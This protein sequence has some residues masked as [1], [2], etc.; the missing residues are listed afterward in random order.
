MIA[1]HENDEL[2]ILDHSIV[3]KGFTILFMKGFFRLLSELAW[4]LVWLFALLIIGYFV[5]SWLSNKFSGNIIGTG[6]TWVEQHA[7]PGY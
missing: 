7:Q 5:L 6:A 1:I 3:I 4:S 2:Y